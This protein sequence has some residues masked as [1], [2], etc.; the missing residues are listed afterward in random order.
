[1]DNLELPLTPEREVF[2]VSSLNREARRLIEGNFGVVWVEG[3]I[4]NLAR[5]SSGHLYWSLKDDNA[6]VRCAM[7]RQANRSLSFAP[8]N[9]QQVL[10]RA[11]VS[12]YEARGDFQLIVDFLEEAG[13]GLLRRRFEELKRKLATEGLFDAERKKPI[14]TLPHRI[15]I[16]TSPSGAAVRDILTILRRRFPWVRALI[17]PTRVQGETAAEEIAATLELADRRGD[18][19][20]LILARGGGSLEDL[21]SFNEEIVARAIAAVETPVISAV[22]HEIDFTIADFVADLRAP[23][24][25][26]AAEIAVPDQ[27]EWL[28]ALEA[29]ARRIARSASQRLE[30][31]GRRA[32]GL[33]HRLSRSHPGI[34]LRES[35]QRLDDLDVRLLRAWREIL[36][37][38]RRTLTEASIALRAA[39]PRPRLQ[40]LGER[41]RW[42]SESLERTMQSRLEALENRRVLA[43]RTLNA[44][45]PHATLDRGY[46]IVSRAQTGDVITAASDVEAGSILDI[47][48][49]RGALTATVDSTRQDE[50]E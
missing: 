4:S 50:T 38:R 41:Y 3:E 7:F 29:F 49:S 48:L 5:P 25:S 26:G 11:R 46:A 17:F 13:E 22:G 34:Q 16:V 31:A 2:S 10:A 21:W 45:G 35:T 32:E 15:G 37:Q 8:D 36:S 44:V 42:A 23:T 18:C 12:L 9:G 43:T 24:P 19:D 6:Q 1:M 47:R 27:L 30:T 33:A 40:A 28:G 39:A 14:P 20:V